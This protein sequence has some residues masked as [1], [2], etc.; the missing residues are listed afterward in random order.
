VKGHENINPC[1]DGGNQ[2]NDLI[3]LG[4]LLCCGMVQVYL[5]LISVTDS[6]QS[7]GA[8]G[9]R[10]RTFCCPLKP[11]A[12]RLFHCAKASKL[13]SLAG[14]VPSSNLVAPMSS[15]Q[16]G[17]SSGGTSTPS[18]AYASNEIWLGDQN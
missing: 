15:A 1:T 3:W 2:P 7:T 6:S 13:A 14:M 9:S 5:P 17:L 4:V 11:P 8:G 18:V 10:A 16:N 12:A